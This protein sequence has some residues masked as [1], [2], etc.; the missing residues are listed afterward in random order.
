MM[1]QAKKSFCGNA[2]LKAALPSYLF[3]LLSS[4]IPAYFLDKPD[5]LKAS[6]TTI[7]MPS[8]F[9]TVICFILLWQFQERQIFIINRIVMALVLGITMVLL[10]LGVIYIFKWETGIWNI[11]IS[12][13]LGAAIVA[14]MKP[15][16]KTTIA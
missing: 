10:A 8:L 9:A 4:A 3:P 16:T 14:M 1:T 7:A 2:F 15:L 11:L 6:Y 12:S 13:F 5:L